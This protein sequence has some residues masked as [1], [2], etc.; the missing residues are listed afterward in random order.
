MVTPRIL[1]FDPL[2]G[3]PLSSPFFKPALVDG[4]PTSPAEHSLGECLPCDAPP[5]IL[6]ANLESLMRDLGISQDGQL[7]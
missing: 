2:Q 1:A 6:L 3:A 5:N 4:I 7:G